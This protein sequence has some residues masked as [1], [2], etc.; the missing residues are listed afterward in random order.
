MFQQ[1]LKL[2]CYFK[3]MIWL[4]KCKF[5][6]V[7]YLILT[8]IFFLPHSHLFTNLIYYATEYQYCCLYWSVAVNIQGFCP[9]KKMHLIV[10]LSKLLAISQ[11]EESSTDL[12][13]ICHVITKVT[14]ENI[15]QDRILQYSDPKL[16]NYQFSGCDYL[17]SKRIVSNEL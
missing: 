4:V 1:H 6:F 15:K 12:T 16:K 17:S 3:I 7:P 10:S 11:E 9:L 13:R 2:Q 5:F 8:I 14:A